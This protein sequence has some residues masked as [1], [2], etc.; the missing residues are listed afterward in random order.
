[1]N[2]GSGTDFDGDNV[3]ELPLRVGEEN[4]TTS[5]AYLIEVKR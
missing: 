5:D 2:P 1:M 3:F 4:L